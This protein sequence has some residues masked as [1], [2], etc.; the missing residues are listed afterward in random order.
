MLSTRICPPAPLCIKAT[1]GCELSQSRDVPHA[2]EIV[3]PV[4]SL[5]GCCGTAHA[6]VPSPRYRIDPDGPNLGR[7]GRARQTAQVTLVGNK[8]I[9]VYWIDDYHDPAKLRVS[10]GGARLVS[11]GSST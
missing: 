5:R 2:F 10:D 4:L 1:Q 11:I 7:S 3:E 9:D 6:Y 8:V